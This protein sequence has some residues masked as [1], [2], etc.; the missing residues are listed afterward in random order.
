WSRSCKPCSA[1]FQSASRGVDTHAHLATA[2]SMRCGIRRLSSLERGGDPVVAGCRGHRSK[3]WMA[4]MAAP[5]CSPAAKLDGSRQ[6]F[7]SYE[8][9]QNGM[10]AISGAGSLYAATSLGSV[11]VR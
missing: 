1:A 9:R 10:Q 8:F 4:R 7:L 6:V 5:D 11:S 2:Q 3:P